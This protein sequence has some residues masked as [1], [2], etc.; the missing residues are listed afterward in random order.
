MDG[1]LNETTIAVMLGIG[2]FITL[3]AFIQALMPSDPMAARLRSHRK[4]RDTLRGH[5]TLLSLSPF[6]SRPV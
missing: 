3:V 5:T 4:R 1:L 2:V 6:N